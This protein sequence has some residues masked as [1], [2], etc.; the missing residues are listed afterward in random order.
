M[1]FL[2]KLVGSSRQSPV[3]FVI[4]ID[5]RFFKFIHL[6]VFDLSLVDCRQF[7]F[8]MEKLSRVSE[9]NHTFDMSIWPNEIYLKKSCIYKLVY[10]AVTFWRLDMAPLKK[11]RTRRFF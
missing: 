1:D 2:N 5:F 7:V 3:E 9:D 6:F 8:L 10:G 11:L 4:C